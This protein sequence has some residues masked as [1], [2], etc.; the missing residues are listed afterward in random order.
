[1]LG[2]VDSGACFLALPPDCCEIALLVFNLCLDLCSDSTVLTY[3]Q[4]RFV[5]VG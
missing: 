1:M 4:N 5:L 3:F 2:F